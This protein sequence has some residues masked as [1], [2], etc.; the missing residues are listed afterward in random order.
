MHTLQ[1]FPCACDGEQSNASRAIAWWSKDR[2]FRK[3]LNRS[4]TLDTVLLPKGAGHYFVSCA[5]EG[6]DGYAIRIIMMDTTT[7]Q[8]IILMTIAYRLEP[9]T[10]WKIADTLQKALDL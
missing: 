5:D 10:V 2:D 6:T 4:N 7:G 1:A 3:I 9:M 8:S